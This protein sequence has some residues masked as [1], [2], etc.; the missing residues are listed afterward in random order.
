VAARTGKLII[1]CFIRNELLFG[2]RFFVPLP[3]PL[4]FP[5]SISYF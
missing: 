4:L 2:R 1:G 3:P 5:I